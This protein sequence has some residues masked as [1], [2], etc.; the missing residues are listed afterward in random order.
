MPSKRSSLLI[1]ILPALWSCAALGKQLLT[2]Q[3]NQKPLRNKPLAVQLLFFPLSKTEQGCLHRNASLPG[4]EKAKLP[5]SQPSQPCAFPQL[6]LGQGLLQ[7]RAFGTAPVSLLASVRPPRSNTGWL[8]PADCSG[9]G[10]VRV[11]PFPTSQATDRNSSSAVALNVCV[12]RVARTRCAR[13]PKINMWNCIPWPLA[14]LT[15]A[16]EDGNCKC[17]SF[18]QT[19]GE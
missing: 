4:E 7:K 2:M 12:F 18:L 6:L 16:C 15:S 13:F 1:Q 19:V 9:L 5:L 11:Q 14:S 17:N 10:S 8:C 3:T